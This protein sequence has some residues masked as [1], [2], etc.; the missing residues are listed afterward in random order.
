[1]PELAT[2]ELPVYEIEALGGELTETARMIDAS[3]ID[4]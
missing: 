2:L 3:G 1:L 4:D